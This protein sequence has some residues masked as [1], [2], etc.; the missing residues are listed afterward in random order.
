MNFRP[1]FSAWS[2]RAFFIILR[3]RL[4]SSFPS[5]RFRRRRRRRRCRRCCCC[6][7]CCCCIRVVIFPTAA[8]KVSQSATRWKKATAGNN[9]TARGWLR[10]ESP[11]ADESQQRLKTASMQTA[12]VVGVVV[13]SARLAQV[14]RAKSHSGSRGHPHRG[15]R[16]GERCAR[17]Q[18]FLEHREARP[19]LEQKGY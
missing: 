2:T 16:A 10:T 12:S 19:R 14:R 5:S 6:R 3:S 7:C 15:R 8:Q 1:L 13:R 18:M 17:F 11:E 9:H 4:V